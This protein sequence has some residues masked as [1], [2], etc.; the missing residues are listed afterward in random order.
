MD[1]DATADT[2]Q[3]GF[4]SEKRSIQKSGEEYKTSYST[5]VGQVRRDAVSAYNN[6][7]DPK[8]IYRRSIDSPAAHISI[9]DLLTDERR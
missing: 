7:P 3:P 6:D 4:T 2:S 5:I 8:T 1:A 9:E